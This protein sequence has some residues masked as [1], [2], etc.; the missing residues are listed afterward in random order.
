MILGLILISLLNAVSAVPMALRA[1][2]DFA[3]L[4]HISLP[5]AI[6]TGAFMN[7]HA[8]VTFAL[9]WLD[10]GSFSEPSPISMALGLVIA[11]AGGGLIAAGRREYAS[12]ARLY[13][14]VEDKLIA[15]GI[16]RYSRNPQYVGYW[17]VLLGAATASLSQWAFLLGFGIVPIIN[18]YVRG[19][20]E[21]HL[22]SA[23]GEKYLAYCSKTPRYLLFKR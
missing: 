15:T 12:R 21:P 6:W 18:F 23:F 9:A 19:V 14:L 17:L 20:E 16:Y 7:G 11:S 8:A 5:V 2:H 22:R 3:R 10:R 4:G 1:R 13:G